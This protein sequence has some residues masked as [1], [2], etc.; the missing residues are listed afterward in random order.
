MKTFFGFTTG[1]L[2][3]MLIGVGV[4]MYYAY[5]DE[6]LREFINNTAEELKK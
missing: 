1:L 5:T 3:G 2:S 6:Q 4:T